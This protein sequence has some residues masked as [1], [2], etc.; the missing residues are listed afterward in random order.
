MTMQ[1]DADRAAIAA[2][3]RVLGPAVLAAVHDLYR[4]EQDTLAAAQPATATNCA[5]GDDPRQ[6]LDLYAPMGTARTAPILL[7]VHGGGFVRGEKASAHHPF[8][9]HIGRWAARHGMLGAVMNYRLAPDH[10]W[11]AGGEDVGAAVDWLRAHAAA[12]G[13]DPTRIVVAGTSAG[14]VHVATHL[15]LWGGSPGV[16][17]AVL[18]SGL[19]GFTQLDERDTLYYGPQDQ[20]SD[21]APRDAVVAT[22]VPLLVACAEFDPPRFQ[23][24]TTGLLAARLAAQDDLPRSH[25]ASGHNHFSLA[26][27]IGGVDT[28]L[29]DEIRQFILDVTR[30]VS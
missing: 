11:P 10:V 2:M 22:E 3:G 6:V 12:F 8:N 13:G 15:R 9:A 19:Y 21:R 28:R 16:R 4:A 29:S 24:E 27:H 25:I 26:A 7:W 14:A 18:L 5:Y 17:G 30:E 23:A 1:P 20:Y